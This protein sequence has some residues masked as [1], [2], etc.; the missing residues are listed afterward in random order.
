MRDDNVVSIISDLTAIRYACASR[1]FA[2]EN[3]P[4]QFTALV[5]HINFIAADPR[6]CETHNKTTI[7]RFDTIGIGT[8]CCGCVWHVENYAR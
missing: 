5:R 3:N 1:E 2:C 7:K 8:A 6:C 4:F